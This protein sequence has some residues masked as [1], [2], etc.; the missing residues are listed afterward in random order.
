MPTGA[1]T[2]RANRPRPPFDT[3]SMRAGLGSRPPLALH[4]ARTRDE[5]PA[6]AL[7]IATLLEDEALRRRMGEAGRERRGRLFTVDR[8]AAEVE[9][10]YL[11]LLSPSSAARAAS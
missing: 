6:L 10:L 1:R 8:M 3:P 9:A 5:L 2:G 7:A 4:Q 11:E